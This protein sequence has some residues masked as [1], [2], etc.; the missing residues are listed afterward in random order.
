MTRQLIHTASWH[1]VPCVPVPGTCAYAGHLRPIPSE[2]DQP[3]PWETSSCPMASISY[4]MLV[5]FQSLS[6]PDL[7]PALK[8]SQPATHW[9]SP[10]GYATGPSNGAY[11]K[12]T[13][14]S[15]CPGPRLL[16]WS[17]PQREW[18]HHISNLPSQNPKTHPQL[19]LLSCLFFS[20]PFIKSCWFAFL[21]IPGTLPLLFIF[22]TTSPLQAT[23]MLAWVTAVAF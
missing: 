8:T 20:H 10:R 19:L 1:H 17:P 23:L 13:P 9:P 3:S 7:P 6:N 22:S 18:S 2:A 21:N 14:S 11:P 12:P 15:P 4:Q 5:T 16:N